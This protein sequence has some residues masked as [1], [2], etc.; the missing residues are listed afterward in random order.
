MR[1]SHHHYY[2]CVSCSPHS[3]FLGIF[4]Y[5]SNF[6][7]RE[8]KRTYG[9]VSI[10]LSRSISRSILKRPHTHTQ[11]TPGQNQP[12]RTKNSLNEISNRAIL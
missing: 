5:V 12:L 7:E 8:D 4:G 11:L 6:G 1:F 9:D 2:Y 3:I 10:S